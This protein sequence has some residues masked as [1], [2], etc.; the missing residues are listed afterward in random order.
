EPAPCLAS[1]F[2]E[3]GICKELVEACDLMGWKEPIRVQAEAIPTPSRVPSIT[4]HPGHTT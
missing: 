4:I 3:V 1:T 2:V